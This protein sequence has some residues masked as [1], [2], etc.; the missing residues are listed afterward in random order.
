MLACCVD[1]YFGHVFVLR[2]SH[3]M[4]AVTAHHVAEGPPSGTATAELRLR[5]P[6]D[7]TVLVHLGRRLAVPGARTIGRG[8]SQHDF[9]AFTVLDGDSSW[10]LALSDTT[11]VVGDTLWVVARLPNGAAGRHAVRLDRST[12]SAFAYTWLEVR[13]TSGTSGAAVIDRSGRVVAVNV[14]TI[15][16]GGAII[17]LAVGPMALRHHL[18]ALR[19]QSSHGGP[20][21]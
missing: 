14:G 1:R 15:E 11:P 16:R 6:S 17:G 9:A 21:P 8:G 3:G 4:I 2:T 18:A 19:N 13:N 12:D 7:S 10:A 20:L 5:S